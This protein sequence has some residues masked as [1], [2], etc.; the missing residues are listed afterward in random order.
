MYVFHRVW[1]ENLVT[2]ET[3][4]KI[5]HQNCYSLIAVWQKVKLAKSQRHLANT[6]K[7]INENVRGGPNPPPPQVR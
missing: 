5:G 7:R 4:L 2:M 1:H 3:R 6:E